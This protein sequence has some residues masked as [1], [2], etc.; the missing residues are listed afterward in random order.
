[1]KVPLCSTGLRPLRGR[2]PASPHSN[3][4]SC[5]A[6]QRVLLTTYCPWA[7]CYFSNILKLENYPLNRAIAVMWLLFTSLLDNHMYLAIQFYPTGNIKQQWTSHSTTLFLCI[8]MSSY[9]PVMAAVAVRKK[10]VSIGHFSPCFCL[11]S[12]IFFSFVRS[13]QKQLYVLIALKIREK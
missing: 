1:M 9:L 10:V 2:C 12:L 5:R 4:Q 6:G 7:T 11:Q 8:V 13:N 3:S